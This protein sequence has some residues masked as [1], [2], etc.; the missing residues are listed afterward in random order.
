MKFPVP[1][2]KGNDNPKRNSSSE[3]S[4]KKAF[5]Q[6][7]PSQKKKGIGYD[8]AYPNL[9]PFPSLE[10]RPI[11]GA[12]A[13]EDDILHEGKRKDKKKGPS[14]KRP[15]GAKYDPLNPRK[16]DSDYSE[17]DPDHYRPRSQDEDNF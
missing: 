12:Y 11:K 13:T 6:L 7:R 16:N 10:G 17:P 14:L 2:K 9:D 5:P 3:E 4:D 1:M 8:D 15:P